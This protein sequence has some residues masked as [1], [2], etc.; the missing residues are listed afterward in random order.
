MSNIMVIDFIIY[1][2]I[3]ILTTLGCF[4]LMSASSAYSNLSSPTC[5]TK[6]SK[7]AAVRS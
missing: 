2:V 6:A 4:C 1:V 7:P 5:R 3:G